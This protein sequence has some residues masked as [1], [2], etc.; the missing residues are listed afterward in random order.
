MA[1]TPTDESTST[2]GG[3]PA[4]A[5]CDLR[6]YAHLAYD[7][8]PLYLQIRQRQDDKPYEPDRCQTSANT[9]TEAV[10][11]EIPNNSNMA[12]EAVPDEIPNDCDMTTQSSPNEIEYDHR[13]Y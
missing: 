6:R 4:S 5:P 12:I 8:R 13:T 1:S 10:P 9:D 2:P 3:E 11:N 7:G